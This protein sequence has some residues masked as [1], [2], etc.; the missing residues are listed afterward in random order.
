MKIPNTPEWNAIIL[1]STKCDAEEYARVVT[2]EVND[3]FYCRIY[4]DMSI[5][6]INY[7]ED[8]NEWIWS[9]PGRLNN[10]KE[11]GKHIL[12]CIEENKHILECIEENNG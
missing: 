2:I 4:N 10:L 12:E 6:F 3:R 9:G 11:C 7:D 5:N 8:R 1:H